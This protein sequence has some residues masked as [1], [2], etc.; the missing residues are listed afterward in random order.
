MSYQGYPFASAELPCRANLW[1]VCRLGERIRPLFARVGHDPHVYFR[2]VTLMAYA[3]FG[4]DSDVYVYADSRG[5]FTCERCPTIGKQ[6]RCATAAE[7]VTHLTD[8][9]LRGQQ[10]PAEAIDQL[11]DEAQG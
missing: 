11:K 10:V 2:E 5:G 6:F 1:R 7:M 3:R 4:R 8:H 9:R